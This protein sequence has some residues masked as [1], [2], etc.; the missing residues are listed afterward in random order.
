MDLSQR[1]EAFADDLATKLTEFNERYPEPEMSAEEWE[2]FKAQ[3]DRV[4]GLTPEKM[5]PSF[6][7]AFCQYMA[8]FARHGR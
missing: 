4:S 6:K 1:A 3:Q 7:A 5:K 2:R 8:S